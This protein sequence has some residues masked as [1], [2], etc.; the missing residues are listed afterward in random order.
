VEA[1]NE[2]MM[3]FG[4]FIAGLTLGYMFGA[5]GPERRRP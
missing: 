1:V 5:F 4:F 2:A 3:C